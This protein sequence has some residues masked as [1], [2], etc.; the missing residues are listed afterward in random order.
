[1]R[2]RKICCLNNLGTK[3]QLWNENDAHFP[4]HHNFTKR[5][6]GTESQFLGRLIRSPGSPRRK[7]SGVL[8]EEE[9]INPPFFFLSTFLF[10]Y[11]PRTDD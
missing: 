9:K 8:K 11:K 10:F 5:K 2:V 3:K 1:M 7:G 4:W 6:G